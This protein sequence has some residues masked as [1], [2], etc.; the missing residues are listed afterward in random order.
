M[1]NRFWNITI[2]YGVGEILTRFIT[3]ALLA[4]HTNKNLFEDVKE[5]DQLFI[6]YP[7]LALMN[8]FYAFGLHQSF[9][10][11]YNKN[12]AAVGTSLF[13][14]VII[15]SLMSVALFSMRGLIDVY[16]F[17]FSET[18]L[19]NNNH[20]IVYLITILVLD[21]LAGRLKVLLRILK[22]PI[23]FILSSL[24]NVV[25][26]FCLT[27]YFL[28]EQGLGLEGVVLALFITSIIQ[29]LTLFPIIYFYPDNIFQ[30]N[31][32]LLNKMFKFGL[33][34]LPAAILL[35]I[36]ELSDRF[37]I[38]QL[39]GDGE[40]LKY[41]A[42]YKIGAI[43]LL[44]VNAF[45]Q[46]WQPYINEQ[47]LQNRST[48]IKSFQKIGTVFIIFL[49]FISTILFLFWENIATVKLAMLRN[50]QLISQ[51]LISPAHNIIPIVIIAFIIYGVFI[52]QMP[53][54]YLKNKQGWVLIFWLVG[55]GINILG[56]IFFISPAFLNLGIEGAALSTLFAYS[57]MSIFI[58]IKNYR[59]L[60]ITY[61]YWL[62]GQTLVMSLLVIT[63]KVSE[64]INI[65][66]L[67]FLSG[68]YAL[69]VATKLLKAYN[70]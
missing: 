37:F 10:K 5:Q 26:S 67:I 33:P 69:F 30:Y 48:S 11:Y 21:A 40:V 57:S 34:F 59:W 46:N 17:Q 25:S 20:W 14:F 38:Y 27:Y 60:R 62:I 68:C 12:R 24:I 43:V 7:F 52:L 65:Y 32:K 35:L 44:A 64:A 22:K 56:N 63:L 36:I 55:G 47:S 23:Y 3:F 41:S 53:S 16:I 42:G 18:F 61:N 2:L 58:I 45:N 39:L 9:F 29:I 51:D 4:F 6:L 70:K 13:A 31:F 19:I 54:I 15:A 66:F 8:A 1:K 28:V 50:S 49:I